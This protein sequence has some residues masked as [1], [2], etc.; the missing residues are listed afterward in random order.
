MIVGIP[1]SNIVNILNAPGDEFI[2]DT[3][4]GPACA[5]GSRAKE[6]I[7]EVMTTQTELIV[8]VEGIKGTALMIFEFYLAILVIFLGIFHMAYHTV[9][10]R[11]GATQVIG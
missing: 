5:E 3:G 8:L 1:E 4:Y 9:V 2:M 11:G 7:A 10:I 6:G